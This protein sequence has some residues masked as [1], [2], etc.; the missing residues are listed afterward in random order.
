MTV[1]FH[2]VARLHNYMTVY[3]WPHSFILQQVQ[4]LLKFS[5]HAPFILCSHD[6]PLTSFFARK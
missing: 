5:T 4:S 2:V 3:I 1:E 6:L